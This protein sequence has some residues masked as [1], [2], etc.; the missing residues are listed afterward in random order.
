MPHSYVKKSW[1]VHPSHSNCTKIGRYVTHPEGKHLITSTL[2]RSINVHNESIV[3][4]SSLAVTAGCHLCDECYWIEQNHLTNESS[5]RLG[6]RLRPR[7]EE[8]WQR[9]KNKMCLE[10]EQMCVSEE[11]HKAVEP[12][13]QELQFREQSAKELLN[14]IF[15][16]LQFPLIRDM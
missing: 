11:V 5:T 10:D 9:E 15:R 12:S 16:L 4:D 7:S 8:G 3:N 14:E 2:A 6:S 13:F 1:C